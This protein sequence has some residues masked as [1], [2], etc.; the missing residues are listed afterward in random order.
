MTPE[1][2]PTCRSPLYIEGGVTFCAFPE[3]ERYNVRQ[4]APR[5]VSEEGGDEAR[6]QEIEA[7]AQAATA[8]PWA[9]DTTE[10]HDMV[11]WGAPGTAAPRYEGDD[12]SP[13]IINIGEPVARIG[14]VCGSS[15]DTHFIAHARQDIPWLLDRVRS[16]ESRLRAAGEDGERI[17]QVF[18][19]RPQVSKSELRAPNGFG[20]ASYFERHALWVRD[21]ELALESLPSAARS[22]SSEPR[23]P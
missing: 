16:L 13:L 15:A 8:G 23:K 3:C 20:I 22:P 2:C 10:P 18:A 19:R 7:R 6:L 1:H 5:S 21:L 4:P 14:D 11:V 12:G 17:R 9:A